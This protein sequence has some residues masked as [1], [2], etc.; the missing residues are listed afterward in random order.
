MLAENTSLQLWGS[1][2]GYHIL[3]T[4][5]YYS[6][7]GTVWRPHYLRN[8]TQ[9][10]VK[11]KLWLFKPGEPSQD[12]GHDQTDL[13]LTSSC[14][15]W[16]TRMVSNM[17]KNWSHCITRGF[18]FDLIAHIV[19][20]TAQ[21]W[22]QSPCVSTI[23]DIHIHSWGLPHE[24]QAYAHTTTWKCLNNSKPKVLPV[25]PLFLSHIPFAW[26]L[27]WEQECKAG[28]F[29]SGLFIFTLLPSP[30]QSGSNSGISSAL[31]HLTCHG[32]HFFKEPVW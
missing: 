19:N 15:A 5:F 30:C 10:I 21:L 11:W 32:Q 17:V 3:N 27:S 1:H 24:T 25:S 13:L 31:T 28:E 8:A 22:Y 14:H 20:S 12:G 4:N 2:H 6:P 9:S 29:Q 18:E 7:H 26:S 16:A 23:P